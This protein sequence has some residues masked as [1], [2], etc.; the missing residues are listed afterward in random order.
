MS[1]TIT[2]ALNELKVLA[3]RI[4]KETNSG[5]FIISH[6]INNAPVGFSTVKAFE[7]KAEAMS[8]SITDLIER[9][10]KIKAAIVKS[11]ALTEISVSGTTYTVAEAIERKN[12]IDFE[13]G[14]LNV[15][16]RQY[17]NTMQFVEKQNQVL[18][19]KLDSLIETTLGKEKS[20]PDAMAQIT[21]NFW[22]INKVEVSN[23]LNLLDKIETFQN[24][25]E[26]FLSKVDVALTI[27]NSTVS[28]EV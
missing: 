7:E 1:I 9:R 25:I 21:E 14:L 16:T 17:Q 11:N 6:K 2:E 20:N 22:H 26:S 27:S 12:S 23:P 28:I 24:D 15:L 10:N 19:G 5:T 13:R 18:Q 4:A 3:N 8:K